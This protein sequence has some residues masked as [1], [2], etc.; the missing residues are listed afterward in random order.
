MAKTKQEMA[1]GKGVKYS[2]NA[3]RPMQGKTWP[4]QRTHQGSGKAA[5]PKKK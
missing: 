2:P 3:S 4:G 1:K 5:A